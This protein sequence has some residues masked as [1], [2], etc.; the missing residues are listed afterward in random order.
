VL[1]IGGPNGRSH[2]DQALALL[3]DVA[4]ATTTAELIARLEALGLEWGV[5][6]GT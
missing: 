3:P 1:H 2:T 4:T 5:S 6:N